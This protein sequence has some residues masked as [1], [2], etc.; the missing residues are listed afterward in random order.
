MASTYTTN[1][2]IEKQANGASNWDGPLNGDMNSIDNAFGGVSSVNCAG[3]TGTIAMTAAGSASVPSYV[4][5]NIIIAGALSGNVTYAIPSGIGGMW[6][7]KNSATGGTVTI[8][9]A[10]GG[11]TVALTAGGV[12]TIVIADGTSNGVALADTAPTTVGGSDTQVQ[13]N[14][15]GVLSGSPKFVFDGSYYRLTSTRLGIGAAGAPAKELDLTGTMRF[16]GSSSG[17]VDIA[18][19]SAAGTQSYVWPVGPPSSDGQVLS[20][21][22]GG[23]W[24]WSTATSGPT[25]ATGAA[26]TTAGPTGPTGATGDTGATG[27][28]GA[29]GPTGPT[30]TTGSGGPTGPTGSS[31]VP[32]NSQTVN[33]VAVIGDAGKTLYHPV[34]AGAGDTF[35]IPANASVAYDVGTTLTFVNMATDAL[36]ISI[37]SDTLYLA[38]A[39]T[40]GSRTLVQYGMATALKLTSTTWIISGTGLA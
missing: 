9:S 14:N 20:S 19:P 22:T 23:V 37:N 38:G 34:G 39:G 17:T 18:A 33:Y 11:A 1:K 27:A 16:N 28:T 35:T 32:I 24:A 26:S 36:T 21:T 2:H 15:A 8:S 25:G 30:G 4:P 5:P 12:R 3:S 31:S 29:G 6:S 13:Y 7:I 40:T 10:A